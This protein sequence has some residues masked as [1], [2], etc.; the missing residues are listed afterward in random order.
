MAR[1]YLYEAANVLL[2]TVKKPWTLKSW[3]SEVCETMRRSLET[4]IKACKAEPFLC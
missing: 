4:D 2:T 1:R 3:G